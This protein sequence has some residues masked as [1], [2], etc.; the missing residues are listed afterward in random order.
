MIDKLNGDDRDASGLMALFQLGVIKC[1]QSNCT[2]IDFL[3]NYILVNG[4]A[5]A[6]GHKISL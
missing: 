2:Q 1:R 6:L 5:I 3:G 4:R